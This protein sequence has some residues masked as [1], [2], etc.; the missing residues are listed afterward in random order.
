MRILLAVLSLLSIPGAASGQAPAARG[1]IAL[2]VPAAELASALGLASARP[3]TVV[4]DAVRLV[5]ASGDAH[6]RQHPAAEALARVLDGGVV[7]ASDVVP[8]PLAPAVWRDVILASPVSDDRL[9][10]AI[11]RDR[12][13]ALMYLGLSALDEETLTWMAAQPDT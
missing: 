2:P 9:I 7:A 5:Y 4:G 11:L 12:G 6:N 1:A 13:A 10:A 3:S 8:L